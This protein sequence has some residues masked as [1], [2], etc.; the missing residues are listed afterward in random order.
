MAT[1]DKYKFHFLSLDKSSLKS[2]SITNAEISSGYIDIEI[3]KEEFLKSVITCGM[4]MYYLT[5]SISCSRKMEISYKLYAILSLI[6]FDS[7]SG[8][9]RLRK[10]IRYLD[11]SEKATLSYYLGM[12][13]TRFI[14]SREFKQDYLV[15]LNILE[16]TNS[17][18]YKNI[19]KK[20]RPD[21]I[22]Y[23]KTSQK[24]SVF[25]AKGRLRKKIATLEKALEQVQN[26]NYIAGS[27]PSYAVAQLSYFK[28][29]ELYVVAVDPVEEGNKKIE[30]NDNC[31]VQYFKLYYEPI[32]SLFKESDQIKIE[33]E[34]STALLE[35]NGLVFYI[36]LPT[37]IYSAFSNNEFSMKHLIRENDKFDNDLINVRLIKGVIE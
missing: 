34:K 17:I 14:S 9:I 13:L 37:N 31:L 21:L 15:H 33:N 4:P 36:E 7:V 22:G 26:V 29:N 1:S 32:I 25:E 10:E 27:K 28:N 12:V 19:N 3:T 30:F 35:I 18:K 5:P 24:F 11:A 8:Y 2:K 6:E 16:K 23:N 20:L